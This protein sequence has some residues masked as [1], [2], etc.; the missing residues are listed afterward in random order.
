METLHLILAWIPIA[1][2]G[3][4]ALGS[5]GG[6]LFSA[7][8]QAGANAANIAAQQQANQMNAN[9]EMAKHEQNTAFMEDA[10]SFNREERQYAEQFNAKQAD[11]MRGYNSTEAEKARNWSESQAQQQMMFQRDM[12]NTAYQRAMADMKAAGL[13]PILAYQ[14]GGGSTPPGAMGSGS[15]ASSGQA[16]SPGAS[17]G[18]ASASSSGTA[19][20]AHVLNDKEGIA[21]AIGNMANNA[22]EVAKTIHGIDLIKEQE[23]LTRQK[24]AESKASETNIN[25]DTARKVEETR[26][27]AGEADNTKAAGDLMRAQANSAGARAALDSEGTRVYQKYDS[28]QAPTLLERIGRILQDAIETG[29]IPRHQGV[30]NVVP[31]GPSSAPSDLWGTSDKIKQR[32]EQNRRKYGQ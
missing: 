20:A 22:A 32:A 13:N 28:P 11:I 18:M 29:K 17:S 14:Q 12:S 2:A 26:R 15:A 8:G 19:R 30:I 3:V 4:S 27:T 25:Q 31:S 10:Q 9:I 7:A 5:L 6:G 24:E 1:A 23:K 21:R 16:S